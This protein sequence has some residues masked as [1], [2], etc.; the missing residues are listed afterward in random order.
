MELLEGRLL[1]HGFTYNGH[2]VG[3]AVA[4]ENLAIIEREGLVDRVRERGEQLGGRLG[5]LASLDVV[6]EVRGEG[7]MWALEI[8]EGDAV[9]L[10]AAIREHGVI[11]RGMETRIVMSP[12][13]VVTR[14][15]I[16][17]LVDAIAAELQRL[18]G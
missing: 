5:E 4:L 17:L 13:F 11:V 3:A 9:A 15:E 8:T 6:K 18:G 10:A 14:E 1:R 16:D 12:P 7:L 2:P